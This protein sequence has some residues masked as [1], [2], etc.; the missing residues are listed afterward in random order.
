MGYMLV[1][2]GRPG[3]GKSTLFNRVVETLRR[4]NLSVAGLIAFE[5][6]DMSGVRIGF[7]IQDLSTG[8]WAWLA[9]RD[10]SSHVRV[11]AYGVFVGEANRIVERALSKEV[12]AKSDVLCVDEV[13]P[14]ELKLPSFKPLLIEALHLGKP[15]ILVVHHRLSDPDILKLLESS[16]K[17]FLT[18]EN[19]DMLNRTLPKSVV[20]RIKG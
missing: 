12:V 6:R 5:E 11:G 16:E 19:R 9:K 4:N 1:I 15:S 2:T 20:E 10:Y 7:K 13:G 8:D 17:L 3:V 14:M 18:F